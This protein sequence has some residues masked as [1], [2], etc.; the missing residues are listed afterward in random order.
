MLTLRSKVRALAANTAF[1]DAFR[2]SDVL[3]R[4]RDR[5]LSGEE[6]NDL[7]S[8]FNTDMISRGKFASSVSN[9]V[10][11]AYGEDAKFIT[12]GREAGLMPPKA[13]KLQDVKI[14]G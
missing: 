5:K 13:V 1:V 10:L 7:I 2:L 6:L 14:V 8:A 12:F 11:E 3:T 9:T 4:A